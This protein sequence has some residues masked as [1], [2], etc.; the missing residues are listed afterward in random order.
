MLS[1]TSIM[2]TCS[3]LTFLS[4]LYL[5]VLMLITGVLFLGWQEGPGFQKEHSFTTKITKR[6]LGNI[7]S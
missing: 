4:L 1:L 6:F 5:S 3:M 7:L 2:L